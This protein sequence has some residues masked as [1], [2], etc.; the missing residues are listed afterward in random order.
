[1]AEAIPNARFEVVPQAGHL[2]PYEN[3]P[4]AN[5]AILQFLMS[6]DAGA[7]ARTA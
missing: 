3:S 7:P 4:A 2:A 1:M 5:G 6:L